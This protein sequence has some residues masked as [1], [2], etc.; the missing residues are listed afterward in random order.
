MT[1]I[2]QPIVTVVG[3]VDHGK[4][5][6]L[7]SIRNTCITEKEAG[8]ITQKI[9]FTSCPISL[10]TGK[11]SALLD[12]YKIKL[13]IPGFLFVDTPGHAAFTNLRK[14]GGSLADL[15]ILVID[16]NEGIM[17]QTAECIEILKVN[18]VP[19]IVALNKVDCIHGWK[20]QNESMQGSIEKQASYTKRE[21]DDL[22]YKMIFALGAYGY[23]ADIFYRV[24]DFTKKVAVVPCSGKRGEGI[25]EL[26]MMLCGLSQ[27]FL[28]EKLKIGKEAKGTVLEIKKEKGIFYAEAIVYDGVLRQGDTILIASLGEPV[29]AKIKT[30]LE[31]LPLCKGYSVAK[32][33]TAASGVRMQLSTTEGVMPGMPFIATKDVDKMKE[34]LKREIADAIEPDN[35]GILIKADSLGSLEAL[36]MLLRKEGFMVRQV[37]I[38]NITRADVINAKSGKEPLHGIILGFNVGIEEGVEAEVKILLNDVIYRL[39]EDCKKWQEEKK[40]EL[41]RESMAEL[42]MPCKLKVLRFVFRQSKPAIFG[43]SVLGG[44]LKQGVMMM[45][46]AGRKI[47]RINAIQSENKSVVEAIKDKEVAVSMEEITFGRQVHEGDILYSDLSEDAF[48]KLKENKKFLTADEINVLQEIAE[49]KRKEKATWGI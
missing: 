35:E 45:N 9:S 32:E 8:G 24:E 23:N 41:E 2:R 26:L 30:L 11:C 6:I 13:Q 14:R 7:D 40:K 21:F 28:V 49:V 48:L 43:V 31:A 44:K 36:I 16:I 10:I 29:S 25:I 34:A 17:P 20:K 1:Q 33:I 46:A 4:T 15:A 5:T 47:D 42:A 39:I 38:G 18:K 12:K 19:F 3:H 22:L 37:G 27:K